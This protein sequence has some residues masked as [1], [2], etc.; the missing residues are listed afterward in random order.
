MDNMKIAFHLEQYFGWNPSTRTH[1]HSMG[2]YQTEECEWLWFC[3]L[4][5]VKR[6]LG[7]AFYNA[8][9]ELCEHHLYCREKGYKPLRDRV[10]IRKDGETFYIEDFKLLKGETL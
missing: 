4:G 5:E 10:K 1:D 9:R 3:T 6:L 2:C 7:R 8:A